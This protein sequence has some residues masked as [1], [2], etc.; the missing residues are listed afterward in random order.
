MGESLVQRITRRIDNISR[1]IEIR[2]PDF[3]MNDIAP[4][5]FERPRL[6]Q[7]FERR[8][9]PKPGHP[10]GEAKFALIAFFHDS[11]ASIIARRSGLSF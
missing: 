1:R 8:L 3:E 2:F 4:L 9:G 10:F 7:N 5:R 6:D 11:E